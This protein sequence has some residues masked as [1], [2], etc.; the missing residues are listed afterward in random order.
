MC[1]FHHRKGEYRNCQKREGHKHLF[2]KGLTLDEA[3]N[4]NPKRHY[5]RGLRCQDYYLSS[6]VMID[7]ARSSHPECLIC[8]HVSAEEAMA[9]CFSW[10]LQ[11]TLS[12]GNSHHHLVVIGIDCRRLLCY[13]CM[14]LESSSRRYTLLVQV[15]IVASLVAGPSCREHSGAEATEMQPALSA[16]LLSFYLHL[17]RK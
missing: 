6:G 5:D 17:S 4:R 1:V 8:S 3:C 15:P 13:K 12:L 11:L 14:Q 16:R 2:Y 10:A 7:G 9:N